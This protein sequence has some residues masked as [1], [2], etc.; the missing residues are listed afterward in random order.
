MYW[1]SVTPKNDLEA[2]T[3]L[4]DSLRFESAVWLQTKAFAGIQRRLSV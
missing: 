3:A 2:P 1:H 4:R